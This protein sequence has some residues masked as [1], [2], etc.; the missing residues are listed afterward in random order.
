MIY[1]ARQTRRK[2]KVLL[3]LENRLHACVFFRM[4]RRRRIVEEWDSSSSDEESDN[5][6]CSAD[7]S[8]EEIESRRP[9]RR[10]GAS[11]TRTT[12]PATVTPQQ[13]NTNPVQVTGGGMPSIMGGSMCADYRAPP[14]QM[15][16]PSAQALSTLSTPFQLSAPQQFQPAP[17]VPAV[18]QIGGPAV[19]GPLP[20]DNR[21]QAYG[22]ITS[23]YPVANEQARPMAN[24]PVWQ[25]PVLPFS[26]SADT[27]PYD[28]SGTPFKL[29]RATGHDQDS[30]RPKREQGPRFTP[31]PQN[32]H[33]MPA[34]AQVQRDRYQP[35]NNLTHQKPFEAEWSLRTG[36][37]HPTTRV[38]PTN[39][40]VLRQQLP[41]H[42]VTG[43]RVTSHPSGL[44]GENRGELGLVERRGFDNSCY[45]KVPF[46]TS[47]PVQAPE[48]RAHI[49]DRPT[50]RQATS[51]PYGGV[52]S[53]ADTKATYV[54]GRHFME[55]QRMPSQAQHQPGGPK[56]VDGSAPTNRF[57]DVAR[58][59]VG[60]GTELSTMQ[61]APRPPV[62]A[63]TAHFMDA[64]RPTMLEATEASVA[65]TN[66][67]SAVAAPQTYTTDAARA[68]VGETTFTSVS[69]GAQGATQAPTV[70]T[71]DDA[72]ATL[73]QESRDY[74][75]AAGQSE[76]QAPMEHYIAPTRLNEKLEIS[77]TANRA[78]VMGDRVNVTGLNTDRVG[79]GD[80]STIRVRDDLHL[81]THDAPADHRGQGMGRWIPQVTV[82]DQKATGESS[83]NCRND[84]Y[85]LTGLAQN[86]YAL[87][88]W[89]Q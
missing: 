48:K 1:C 9:R 55:A 83:Q 39:V 45:Y 68:T 62:A 58:P 52:A 12:P 4:P 3:L 46:P 43:P 50:D 35:S 51:R 22:N 65:V 85:V 13:F 6:S 10:G 20:F 44:F 38:L 36:G 11:A 27:S 70:Y 78:P 61:G 15:G 69:G 84:D 86:P 14:L 19:S 87:P 2:R 29:Y 75:G 26:K 41:A 77:M 33:G 73:K 82:K 89:S 54:K 23:S 76:L 8:A 5:S 67:H 71:E 37:F 60:E 56:L 34:Q 49:V 64:A 25:T 88:M 79:Y 81:N 57:A 66:A 31:Q 42:Y 53:A 40:P 47:A 7:D 16:H 74:T 32:I 63:G 28:V 59:T 30:W 18:S 80:P 72:R 24:V 17:R 21:V